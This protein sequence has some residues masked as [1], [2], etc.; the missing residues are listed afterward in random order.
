MTSPVITEIERQKSEEQ[1]R[2]GM[3]PKRQCLQTQLPPFSQRPLT[4]H[5]TWHLPR[6]RW[7]QHNGVRSFSGQT[8]CPGGVYRRAAIQDEER[9]TLLA[10][11]RQHS[12]HNLASPIAT[13]VV[14]EALHRSLT[15][16]TAT[17]LVLQ[18]KAKFY[19]APVEVREIMRAAP[20]SVKPCLVDC[21]TK[22]LNYGEN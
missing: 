6:F 1:I 16:R 18:E 19:D 9:E 2:N 21:K 5:K 10:I 8:M 11:E 12:I 17:L 14:R 15:R 13:A 4:E 3:P 22:M 7:C 20:S